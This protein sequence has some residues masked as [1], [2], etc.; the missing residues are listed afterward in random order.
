ML[1]PLIE[2]L[3]AFISFETTGIKGNFP[4]F[5]WFKTFL[6]LSSHGIKGYGTIVVVRQA[7][8]ECFEITWLEGFGPRFRG[9]MNLSRV[10][11][12]SFQ[13]DNTILAAILSVALSLE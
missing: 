11:N 13:K 7:V 10:L 6:F 4:Y 3:R 5:S 9:F 2:Y 12:R 8:I 1:N